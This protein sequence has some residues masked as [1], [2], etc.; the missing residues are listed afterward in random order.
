MQIEIAEPGRM[1]QTGS[2]LQRLIQNNNMPVLDLLVREAIQN[3]LDARK[4]E[5]KYVEVDFKT[6][7]FNSSL[8]ARELEELTGAL[9][10]RF[11][12][13][14]CNYLAVRDSH[15]VGLTGEMD[16]RKVK[17]NNYGNLLKLV[18]EICKPQE[19]EGAGGSWGIGKTVY[20][21]MGIGLVIYYSRIQKKAG[22]FESRLVASLVENEAE[23]TAMIPVYRDMSKRGIAWWGEKIAENVTQPITDESYINEFLRIFSLQP[24]EKEETGTTIIIPYI[25]P[26]ELLS[27]NRIEYSDDQSQIFVPFWGHEIEEYIKVSAQ[28]WYAP[29]LNNTKYQQGAFLRLKING[30]GVGFDEMEPIFKVVQSLYNRAGYVVEDDILSEVESLGTEQI[31]VSRKHLEESSMGVL[32][33]AKVSRE[34]LGMNAPYYKPEPYVYFNK[35]IRDTTGNRPTICFTRKPAMI[36]SYENEG[37]WVSDVPESSKDEYIIGLFVL[38][39]FNRLKNCTSTPTIE[40]YIRKSEMAD[41]TSWSDWSDG[42]YNPRFV[43]KI[44]K[45]VRNAISREFA[46]QKET[47]TPKQISGFGKLF[48]D[49]LLPPD[50]FGKGA[51]ADPAQHSN[52]STGRSR[53]KFGIDTVGVQYNKN[54]M[55]I[56][57]QLETSTKKRISRAGFEMLI[58]S[59]SKPIDLNYWEEKLGLDS[60]FSIRE[61]EL[62][63]E[64]VD[65]NKV[66]STGRL[67]PYDTFAAEGFDFSCRLSKKGTCYGVTIS[68]E[69]MRYVKMKIIVVV[70]LNRRDVKPAFFFEKE[71]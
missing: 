43:S 44:Q 54:I 28:R 8:L 58:A 61:V 66:H 19:A 23:S 32:A 59:E 11:G 56:T 1:T 4:T 7:G 53:Y 47:D 46:V 20:F 36:V 71:Q 22:E 14:T 33:F 70:E 30:K 26:D 9:Q 40:E 27:S 13:E 2:S 52:S 24:Y 64:A 17:D 42:Q 45:K 21:R 60:P 25:D 57:I 51:G 10:N 55:R 67:L 39:S 3:S 38:N 6:G 63:I 68:S 15:T 41:H 29:R 5:S 31:V 34:L 62:A 48:G 16:Y 49:M 35:E 69:E 12:A 37:A 18:Y 50:G 65:G